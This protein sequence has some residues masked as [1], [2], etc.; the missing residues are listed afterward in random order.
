MPCADP[1]DRLLPQYVGLTEAEA[2]QKAQSEGVPIRTSC[3]DGVSLP[4][5]ADFRPGRVNL[6]VDSGRVLRAVQE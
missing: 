3:R 2:R 1:E 6:V 4:V 5:T